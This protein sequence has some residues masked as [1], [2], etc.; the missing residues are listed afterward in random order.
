MQWLSAASATRCARPISSTIGLK[1]VGGRLLPGPTGPAAAFFMYEG[2]SGERF[3]HLLP[4][5]AGAAE[6]A[7]LPR[8]RR[9]R[10]VLLGRRRCRPIVVSGPADRARLQKVAEAVYQQI[11]THQQTGSLSRCASRGTH[12]GVLTPHHTPGTSRAV[13]LR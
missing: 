2:A 3:T 7:A 9:G 10:L 11:E 6:R 4:P 5:R 13:T 8:R 1:L 12:A